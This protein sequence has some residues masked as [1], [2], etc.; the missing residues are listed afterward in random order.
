MIKRLL[1]A[2][3]LVTTIINA[4]ESVIPEVGEDISSADTSI[5]NDF[6]TTDTSMTDEMTTTNMTE[7]YVNST[8]STNSTPSLYVDTV[9]YTITNGDTLFASPMA[10]FEV[11]GVDEQSG[12]QSVLVSVDGSEYSL[13]KHPISFS[14]E[15]EHTLNYQF[16]D[17]VG[18]ISYSK[19]FSLTLDATAPRIVDLVLAPTSY[20]TAGIEYIG[21]NTE[22]SFTTYDD[23]TGVGFVEY[24]TNS[25]DMIRF[26]TNTTFA[27]LGYTNTGAFRFSYQATDM[28]SNVSL[29]KSRVLVVDGAA[30]TV[31]VFAK[32]IEVDGIRYISS[33][34]KITVE[35]FDIDTK[36]AKMFYA[37]NDGEFVEY[38]DNIGIYLKKSGEYTIHAKATDVVGNE[39]VAV[40]YKVVVDML[41]PTGDAIYIGTIRSSEYDP[42]KEEE[43]VTEESMVTEEVI[44]EEPVVTEEVI[45]EEPVVTEEVTAE[46][47]VVTE[48]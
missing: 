12:L 40:E 16:V 25:Q 15:G 23:L 2:S 9:E 20:K 18:N 38:N 29:M 43:V 26:N 30:P 46:E 24:S 28:V 34:D 17:R 4:Q 44:A 6:V 48:E 37:I 7:E 21:P 47:P 1:V 35:A 8:E 41:A 19:T 39:S 22:F 31:S 27:S 45:T 10:R 3:L 11:N 5:T 42:T 32:A 13:Y 36:V 14:E 33:K